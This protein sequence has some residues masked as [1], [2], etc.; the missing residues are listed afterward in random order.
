MMAELP[1]IDVE[2]RESTALALPTP[3]QFDL[4]AAIEASRDFERLKSALLDRK[5]HITII[6]GKDYV[7]SSGWA[8]IGTALGVTCE[9]L[10]RTGAGAPGAFRELLEQPGGKHSVS[11]SATYRA[12]APS[13]R[14]ED[15]PGRC[16][17]SEK[18][19]SHQSEHGLEQIACT[20]AR[21]K[22]IARLVG[23]A[24]GIVAEEVS[25]TYAPEPVRRYSPTMLMEFA[26]ELNVGDF[27]TFIARVCPSC[28]DLNSNRDLKRAL[29]PAES[30]IIYDA[31]E[32]MG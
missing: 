23:G 29:T 20:R 16:D 22:A 26:N 15:A 32:S 30:C 19:H 10:S 4:Q 13:G 31:L 25:P 14:H 17:T 11:Y 9:L 27:R 18:R 6:S 28:E 3:Q 12:I 7:N 5:Q 8:V 21:S 2:F 1:A 24:Q